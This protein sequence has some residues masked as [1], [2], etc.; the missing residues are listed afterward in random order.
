MILAAGLTSAWQ[1][2]L[3]FGGVKLGSVNRARQV[4]ECAGGKAVNIA[5][6][7]HRL[8]AP[9]RLLTLVGGERGKAFLR[10]LEAEGVDVRG[11][12]AAAETRVCTT[13]LEEGRATELV[14]NLG[15]VS[16]PELAGFAAAFAEE[17]AGARVVAL[18]GSLPGGTP[19]TFYR[20]MISKAP[21]R[22]ILDARGPELLEALQA[23]PFLVKPNRRELSETLGRELPDERALE[24]AM[25]EVVER[26]AAWVVVT[27]GAG[28]VRVRGAGR[29]AALQ[30]PAVEAVN[31]IG[32]G[33]C[34]AAGMALEIDRGRDPVEA[35]RFGIAAAA[36]K[37]GRVHP[38][39]VEAGR[40][41]RL[42]ERVRL[43][44]Y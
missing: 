26:G 1:R 37:L 7:L 35:V 14:E 29:T 43:L 3:S 5:V 41:A 10:H 20:D 36:D 8:G 11:V 18:S 16:P 38:A 32:C 21:G 13:L 44:Y 34:L 31:P 19:P 4:E 2:L 15:A 42:V 27:D 22:V 25:A 12:G 28:P 40:A 39:G 6:A 33:D 17:A 30:P 24:A 9:V 23:R